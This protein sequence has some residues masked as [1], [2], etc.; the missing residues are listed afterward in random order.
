MTRAG[1][2][3]ISEFSGNSLPSVITEPAPTMLFLPIFAPFITIE[4]DADQRAVFN[5]AAVQDD[6]VADGAVLADGQGKAL[7][8]VARAVVLHIGALT[9]LD[10]FVVAAQHRAEPDTRLLQQTDLADHIGRV[11]DKVISAG[12]KIRSLPVE[13]VDCR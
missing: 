3:M 12:R 7:V 8:G 10:P 5:R 2:P 9:D 6:V 4:P 11:G 1:D 13:F